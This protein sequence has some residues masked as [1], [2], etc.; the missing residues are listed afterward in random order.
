MKP[1]RFVCRLFLFCAVCWVIASCSRIDSTK[2]REGDIVFQ[3]SLSQQ[4]RAIQKATSS[5]FSHMGILVNHDNALQV[6]EAVQPVK[7]TK[8]DTWV[9]RGKNGY[10]EVK[11]YDD[12][13]NSWNQQTRSALHQYA[14]N[15]VGKNYDRLFLW[16]DDQIY[17][18]ELVWKAYQRCLG[19]QLCPLKHLRDFNLD[20]PDVK[21]TLEKRYGKNIPLDEVV[22]SPADI[23][24]SNKLITVR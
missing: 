7:Y 17:C 18:S 12:A 4:S 5:K 9:Q 1:A 8:I 15:N 22:V 13:G 3:V 14:Q 10:F 2:Y 11:R 20:D 19:V 24:N 16:N 6:L 21:V 23:Y